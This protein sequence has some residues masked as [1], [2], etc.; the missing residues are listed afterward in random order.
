MAF[1]HR[2]VVV[3][4]LAWVGGSGGGGGVWGLGGGGGGGGTPRQ[5]DICGV[6]NGR[7][8][9]LDQGDRGILTAKNVSTTP[10]R[11]QHSQS[12]EQCSVEIVTCPSCV[13]SVRFRQLSLAAGC[14]GGVGGGVTDSPCRCDYVWLSE[15]PYDDVSGTPFCGTFPPAVSALQPVYR[16]Q[17]RTLVFT[18]L[19]SQN[20]RHA[21]TLEYSAERNRQILK[22]SP[23]LGTVM[24]SNIT[25]GGTFSSPF[26]PVQ[27]SRDYNAE[28]VV[29]CE[30]DS[31]LT[32][33]IRV[34]FSDFL[35]ADMSIMEFY[36]WNGQRLDVS[37][38]IEFRPPVI[39]SSGPS[40][41]IRFYANGGS[42]IGY[43]AS[44]SFVTGTY[45]E[46][47]VKP[48]TDCGGYVEN[49]GGA[50]TMM[51]M[52]DRAKGEKV[53]MYDCIWLIKPPGNFYHLK[54]H[55]YLKIGTFL[56]MAGNT[57]LTVRQGETSESPLL[58][59]MRYPM[60]Q[61][62][63]SR[64]R[65]HMRE[66]VVPL[67]TGFYVSLR[68]TFGLASRLAIIYSAFTYMDCYTGSDFLCQNHR[69]IP[70][71]LS[72]D[73]FDHCGD[74]SDE[75]ESCSREW[76]AQPVD[77]RWYSHTPNYY[78]PK[79]ERYP[80]L[81]TATLIFIVSSIGLITLIASLVILLYR[82]G[83]RSRQQRELQNRLQTISELLDGTRIEEEIPVVDEPPDYEAPPDYEE[84][85][86]SAT[87]SAQPRR[88]RRQRRSRSNPGSHSLS[89][90]LG[91]R[92]PSR[93]RAEERD[94]ES[95]AVDS[96]GYQSLSPQL[97]MGLA[98][99]R[100][101]QVT[102]VPDS[103]PPPYSLDY[104]HISRREQETREIEAWTNLTANIGDLSLV[105]TAPS[106]QN[107]DIQEN[108]IT[109]MNTVTGTEEESQSLLPPSPD[110]EPSGISS[111]ETPENLMQGRNFD[112][113][114]PHDRYEPVAVNDESS[115]ER[116]CTSLISNDEGNFLDEEYSSPTFVRRNNRQI[117]DR[118][119]FSLDVDR[120]RRRA[121]ASCDCDGACACMLRSHMSTPC[122]S[123]SPSPPSYNLQALDIYFTQLENGGVGHSNR[124]HGGGSRLRLWRSPESSCMSLSIGSVDNLPDLV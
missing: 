45:E 42:G 109:C 71:I 25:Q 112:G 26:F 122:R 67:N 113:E 14:S 50:I 75:P 8:L 77:R 61:L 16:S 32:C 35:L 36:D 7:R 95:V 29:K 70:A 62:T 102:P 94:R 98:V 37:S 9:Y 5:D 121:Q 90:R 46:K 105:I 19:F 40:L 97:G 80:D 23:G 22:G 60:A 56:D 38:G 66:H 119:V 53:R 15:P 11:S 13:I 68:G 58:E 116:Q 39:L 104:A 100:S 41:L 52:V 93:D 85:I 21:F 86:K 92:S 124:R 10:H 57:E 117:R 44:Y 72:C 48:V 24:N 47:L 118:H 55:L 31:S 20:H 18:L 111:P 110:E 81:K 73:G 34:V 74:G 123:P 65:P 79:M 76:D 51:N 27:Y 33:R 6:H 108:M 1:L 30:A 69:C 88:K 120:L 87:G 89:R 84:I 12:H 91:S 64:P 59:T 115:N 103:P 17:T 54:T 83:A 107:S 43:K 96:L 2:I 99:N 3:V 63:G 106:P 4:W 78:F 101:C 28:Y 114:R 82:M 49:L